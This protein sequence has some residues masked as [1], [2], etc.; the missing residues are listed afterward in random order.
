MTAASRVQYRYVALTALALV[1][2]AGP[3]RAA[4]DGAGEVHGVADAFAQPGVALAWGVLRGKSEAD[5]LVVVRVET[6]A[7]DYALVAADG[8]DPFTQQRKAIQQPI[9][10]SS[11]V[12]L[13]IARAHFA[14]FPRTEFRFFA[15][16]SAAAPS[17]TLYFLGVPDTT[18]E[19]ATEEAL[20][21]YLAAR[22]VRERAATGVSK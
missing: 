3:A 20:S 13:R 12:D 19:F 7:P 9:R 1:L 17:L 6:S 16:G 14:Q 10:A 21:R 4:A 11:S 2:C 15:G 5:A 8:I 18:P 22:L